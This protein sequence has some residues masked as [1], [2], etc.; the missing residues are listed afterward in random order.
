MHGSSLSC[1][2]GISFHVFS[3]AINVNVN[4]IRRGEEVRE[5]RRGTGEEGQERSI[6]I[7][8]PKDSKQRRGKRE[9]AKGKYEKQAWGRGGVLYVIL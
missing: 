5:G 3:T 4:Q 2:Y 1:Y 8:K 6:D 7:E 9:R